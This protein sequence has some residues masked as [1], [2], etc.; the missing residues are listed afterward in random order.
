MIKFVTDSSC[1]TRNY[2]GVDINIAPLRIYTAEREFIDDENIDIHEML[3]YLLSFNDRSYTACP[4]AATWLDAFEGA[5]E[6]YVV[7]MTSNLSG[8]YNSACVAKEQYLETHP[9]AN[10]CIIDTLSTGPEMRLILEKL[11][12]LKEDGKTFEEVTKEIKRYQRHTRLFFSFKSLHNFAQ[13]GRV[14]KVV[15][16]AVGCLNISLMGT[17]SEEGTIKPISKC[18]GEKNVIKSLVNTLTEAGFT[19]GKLRISHV[20]NESLATAFKDKIT[21]L[22]PNADVVIYPAHGLCSYYA[23]RE[24]LLIGC[25]CN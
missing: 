11:I 3:N 2:N 16:S 8:T 22:Y 19:G 17:A 12:E 1:D 14:S 10:I 18:R 6:I 25:E 9:N 24:G 4:S 7:T 21:S 23:E 20:E 15:A 5:D 13:N